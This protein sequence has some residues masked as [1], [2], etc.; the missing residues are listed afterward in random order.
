MNEEFPIVESPERDLPEPRV[1]A[2]GRT[3]LLANVTLSV[4]D[5]SDA[6]AEQ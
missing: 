3:A 2:L 4:L 6:E 5:R 1:R